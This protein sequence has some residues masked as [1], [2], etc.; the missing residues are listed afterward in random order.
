MSSAQAFPAAAATAKRSR[1]STLLPRF[2]WAVLA[3]NVV[4]IL[5]G[6][7]SAPPAQAP[8]AAII[9]RSATAWSCRAIHASQP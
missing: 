8:A 5:W 7:S 4:V 1:A 2:A 6:A 9:G 3:Y